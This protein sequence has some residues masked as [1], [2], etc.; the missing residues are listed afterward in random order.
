MKRFLVKLS[1]VIVIS[2]FFCHGGTYAQVKPG[3]PR[4]VTVGAGSV[5]GIYFIWGAAFAKLIND[6]M[7]IPATAETHGGPVHNTQLVN[8]KKLDFGL[9]TGAPLWEGRHGK[10]WAK[11]KKY[12]NTRV[13]FPMYPAYWHAYA[14]RK[15][16]IK[17]M[18]DF[19][20]KRIGTGPVGSTPATYYPHLFKVLG[21]KPARIVN[22]TVADLNSQLKDGMLHVN[23][24][25]PGIPWVIIN[26]IEV[27][28]D[29]NIVGIS[30][31]D[32]EKFIAEYPFFSIGV[33][34]KGT[35]K[36]NK[37]F[38]IESMTIWNFMITNKDA[39]VDF[40]YEVVKKTFENV[41]ILIT[42]HKSA[43]NTKPENI[44]YSP[45][46]L[47]PGAVKYYQEKG[48]RLPEKILPPK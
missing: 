11:G 35:Y 42:A 32:A 27:T 18:H 1:I 21:I 22:G 20:G 2:V 37:D 6:V 40:V 8:I 45:I 36:T 13:I 44:V 48:I 46:P 26:E 25:I 34:P 43:L 38:E 39:P 29:V 47:H 31:A 5:G 19:T 7:G 3:W 12:E 24:S 16:G 15:S 33:I 23:A 4:N 10:G 41:N 14:L 17:S 9:A 30:K 28:H